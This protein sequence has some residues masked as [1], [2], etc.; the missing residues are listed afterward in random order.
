MTTF[1]S[2]LKEPQGLWM[3]GGA[4]AYAT[5]GYVLGF[6]G[7][8]HSSLLVNA[9]STMLLA[10][11]MTIAA[12]LI[13]ECGHN[14]VFRRSRHNA[15][16]GRAM[17]WL[18]GAAYGTYED[19]RYK[20]F[21]HHV[22][23]DDVVW[24]EYDEFFEKHPVVTRAVKVLEWFY[25]PAHDLIMHFIMVFTSFIIPQRR[26]QRV[27]NVTV[28]L[29]LAHAHAFGFQPDNIGVEVA[30]SVGVSN[31]DI[32]PADLTNLVAHGITL[33][34]MKSGMK[35]HYRRSRPRRHAPSQD[36]PHP[37]DSPPAADCGRAAGGYDGIDAV[38]N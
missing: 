15:A 32:N 25:I 24:F 36:R 6:A 3:N 13:H 28:I 8:F 35:P 26:D 33:V 1:V 12:Y 34:R 5:F 31:G 29:V 21:R 30:E 38:V 11:A 27:R 4:V 2:A 20:H 22:D 23:N 18:C 37:W 7:L 10:H 16:L 17:S 14:L 9:I 19:M